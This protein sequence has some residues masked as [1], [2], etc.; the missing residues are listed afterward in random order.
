MDSMRIN[1]LLAPFLE[2]ETLS[3][4]QLAQVAAYL[5]LLL[6]WNVKMNLTAVRK[7]EEIIIRHF[8]ESFFAARKLFDVKTQTAIDLGSGAG[9]PGLPM[10]IYSPETKIT[11]IESQN[12]KATFL[13]EV[14]R[15]LDQKNVAVF[16]GRAEDFPSKAALVCLRAVEKFE[17]ASQVAAGLV[18]PGGRLALMISAAQQAL[19]PDGFHWDLGN[20]VPGVTSR[21][22]AIGR[23]I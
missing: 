11:L 4:S 5:D 17:Q 7:P 20:I 21:V 2:G 23:K 6:K 8:G 10:A 22:L 3:E 14:A 18:E 13:K 1:Q 19:L 9:F 12:K 16:A 15:S